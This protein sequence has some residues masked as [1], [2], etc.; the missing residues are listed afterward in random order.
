MASTSEAIHVMMKE[1]GDRLRKARVCCGNWDRILGPSATEHIGVTACL[2]DPPYSAEADRD[3]SLY[4][5]EDL[6]VVHDVRKW[7]LE[8]GNNKKYRIAL[9]GYEGE[10]EMPDDWQCVAWKANGGYAASAGNHANSHRERIWFSPHCIKV[11]AP[12]Q[13]GLFEPEP[14][15][16]VSVDHGSTSLGVTCTPPV[17]NQSGLPVWTP[18]GGDSASSPPITETEGPK[19]LDDPAQG[20]ANGLP[21]MLVDDMPTKPRRKCKL[22]IVEVPDDGEAA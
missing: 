8:H 18:S 5:Q 20:I 16:D 15:S 13:M 17:E 7:A 9:C 4:N 22:Y 10:H 11:E 1:L 2:L 21:T 6:N 14:E 3:P 12:R 19:L